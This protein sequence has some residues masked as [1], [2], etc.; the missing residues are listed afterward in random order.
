MYFLFFAVFRKYNVKNNC[1]HSRRNNTGTTK[2][3]LNSRFSTEYCEV[4]VE[5]A[6]GIARCNVVVVY[7]H[8]DELGDWYYT[9][10]FYG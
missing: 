4:L 1:N 9:Y 8:T 5:E 10:V 6:Y 7:S 2:N 3:Q